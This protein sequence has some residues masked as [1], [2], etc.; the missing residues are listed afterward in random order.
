MN[1]KTHRVSMLSVYL[2]RLILMASCMLREH[3]REFTDDITDAGHIGHLTTTYPAFSAHFSHLHLFS[4]LE[5]GIYLIHCVEGNRGLVVPPDAPIMSPVECTSHA[6]A[7]DIHVRR[8]GNAYVLRPVQAPPVPGGIV[9]GAH[10]NADPEMVVLA[11]SG[12]EFMYTE[13]AIEHNGDDSDELRL[14][15]LYAHVE[16]IRPRVLA[17]STGPR[18]AKAHRY[19]V[20][21][22]WSVCL[23]RNGLTA[24]CGVQI[25]LQGSEGKESQQWVLKKIQ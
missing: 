6:Q 19:V 4:M 10:D 8:V 24:E 5:E 20:E 21:S 23:G 25:V 14:N 15:Q 16:S 22:A 1:A 9:L 2:V 11:P 13:W 3:G 17:T 12:V 18:Q 7:S